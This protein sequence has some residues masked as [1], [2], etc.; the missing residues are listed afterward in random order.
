MAEDDM[1]KLFGKRRLLAD[2]AVHGV[3]DDDHPVGPKQG[4]RRPVRGADDEHLMPHLVAE[5]LE[6]LL[7]A[8]SDLGVLSGSPGIQRSAERDT[9]ALL[10][11]EC[12]ALEARRLTAHE[13]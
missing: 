7:A 12:A 2:I 3:E 8:H 4:S 11:G 13:R 10:R 1:G 5:L 6:E 9:E